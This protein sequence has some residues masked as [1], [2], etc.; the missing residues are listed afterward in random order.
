M[1]FDFRT[2]VDWSKRNLALEFQRGKD[3]ECNPDKCI[4]NVKRGDLQI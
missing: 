2:A 3:T 1:K 4:V